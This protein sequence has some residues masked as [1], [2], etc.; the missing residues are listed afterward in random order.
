MTFQKR[1]TSIILAGLVTTAGVVAAAEYDMN[2]DI[3]YM[4]PPAASAGDYD[5]D[6]DILYRAPLNAEAQEYDVDRDILYAAPEA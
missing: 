6:R 1:L 3:L 5:T 4:A 2:R